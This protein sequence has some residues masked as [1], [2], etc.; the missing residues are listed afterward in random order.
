[1]TTI[2]FNKKCICGP[3]FVCVRVLD[4]AEELKVGSIYL[5]QTSEINERLAFGQIENVGSKAAEEYGLA[6]GDYVLY[7]RLSTFAHTAPI[8]LLKYNNVICK[9]SE[10]KKEFKP[11]RN[12]LFVEPEKKEH[13]QNVNGVFVPNYADALNVGKI[14]TMNCDV[15][16]NL[17][18]KTGDKVILTKGGDVVQFGETTIY[19]YKYDTI[20]CTVEED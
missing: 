1:M 12:M 8:C 15:E 9:A 11:L 16:L 7:D 17:P 10:D 19:I 18:F 2:E 13:L 4:N 3:E 5:P 6:N 14:T 20:I